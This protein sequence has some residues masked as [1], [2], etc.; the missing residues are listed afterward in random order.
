MPYDIVTLGEP[1][2]RLSPPGHG[3][4][5]RAQRLDLFVV[6]SQLNVAS[7]LAR[8]GR[9]A[10]FLTKLPDN[11]LGH[12]VL[13]ACQSYGL[14]TSHIKM[15]AGAKMGTTYVEFSVSPRQPVAI[16][17]RSGSAAST[18]VASDFDWGAVVRGTR[19]AYTDGIFPALGPGCPGAALAF[20]EA[21]RKE[22]CTTCFDVNF[23]EH[24]WTPQEARESWKI[25][26]PKIDILVT[27]RFVSESV[28]GYEGTDRELLARYREEFGC[29]IVCLTSRE[30]L[31]I[32]EGAWSA[33]ALQEGQF[34]NGRRQVF[35]S[36]DRY[37][38][39][40]AWFSGFLY[41]LMEGEVE[42]ALNFATALC[43]LAHTVE[44]DVAHATPAD[45]KAVLEE[46]S[47]LSLRR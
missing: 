23:R 22:D 29:R 40:D 36:V 37:G 19:Y 9:R 45:V 17:D 6:G 2:L 14:D 44:G 34:Y 41:G 32:G 35:G 21:A 24:L 46:K 38:T 47:S 20:L 7:N 3:Q 18:I 30:I 5:R 27:N 33:L 10:A 13:D 16:Y 11:P 43:A 39:G 25:L 4:L 42:F 31:G 8:L 12:L 26:F 28:F 15:I 1:L